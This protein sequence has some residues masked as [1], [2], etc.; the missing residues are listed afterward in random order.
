[1]CCLELKFWT[2]L[3]FVNNFQSLLIKVFLSEAHL[4]EILVDFENRILI[5]RRNV[6]EGKTIWFDMILWY[7]CETLL[8]GKLWN[9]QAFCSRSL[10]VKRSY[11]FLFFNTRLEIWNYIKFK[12]KRQHSLARITARGNRLVDGFQAIRSRWFAQLIRNLIWIPNFAFT[13]QYSAIVPVCRSLKE[14]EGF[15]EA[16]RFF[17]PQTFWKRRSNIIERFFCTFASAAH[18]GFLIFQ[19]DKQSSEILRFSQLKD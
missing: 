17:C 2:D 9:Q 18:F 7:R 13:G 4:D 19:Q 10:L 1:M 6:L 3:Q 11:L 8:E 5:S 14:S 15:H 16:R 12:K